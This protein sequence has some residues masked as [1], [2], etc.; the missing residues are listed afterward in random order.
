[1]RYNTHV[2]QSWHIYEWVMAHI[3]MRHGTH[4]NKS[5][6][7]SEWVMAHMWMSH[8]THVNASW[9]TCEYV[10]AHMWMRGMAHKWMSDGTDTT[11]SRHTHG[12]VVTFTLI[13]TWNDLVI[14]VTGII[15]MS[16]MTHDFWIRDMT[17]SYV[18]YDSWLV[19]TWRR[20]EYSGVTRMYEWVLSHMWMSP[21]T[22]MN[23][24]CH[25][26]EWVMT[27]DFWIHDMTHSYAWGDSFTCV[28]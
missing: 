14:C 4:V 11:V 17:H 15:H 9:H 22:H 10:M 3:W 23:E 18:T 8:G 13:V 24:S 1:M 26:Y 28:T 21:V 7:K 2:N 6:R 19:N 25:T 16:A 27:R 5:W 20:G 12:H